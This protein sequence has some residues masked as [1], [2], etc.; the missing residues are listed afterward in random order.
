[1]CCVCCWF[2][3]V[4]RWIFAS[5]GARAA[6]DAF[7]SSPADMCVKSLDRR[8]AGVVEPTCR[9]LVDLSENGCTLW[10]AVV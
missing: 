5:R 6:G 1:M 10:Q 9:F 2:T 4:R 7:R 3:R 8:N